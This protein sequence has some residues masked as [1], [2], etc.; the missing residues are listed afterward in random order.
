MRAKFDEIKELLGLIPV[1]NLSSIDQNGEY[2]TISGLKSLTPMSDLL[3]LDIILAYNTLECD[4]YVVLDRV[5]SVLD[6]LFCYG[7]KTK[8]KV[9]DSLSLGA[10][11][12]S[13]YFYRIRVNL[14]IKRVGYA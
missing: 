4:I 2:L 1:A 14:N 7:A 11:S 3:S 10:I 13:L 8:E 5:E 6:E 12:E 9:F